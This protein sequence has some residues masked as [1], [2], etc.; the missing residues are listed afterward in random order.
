MGYFHVI[1]A[2]L[3]WGLLPIFWKQLSA[4]SST[5]VV[6]HRMLW[7]FVAMF[8]ILTMQKKWRLIKT[9]KQNPRYLLLCLCSAICIASNWFLFIWA[10][11]EGFIIEVSLG[12]FINP[13]FFVVLGALIFREKMRLGQVVA[14]FIAVVGVLYLTFAYGSF[15]YVALLLGITFTIYGLIRRQVPLDTF[16]GL[17]TE[18]SLFFVPAI[19]YLG[20]LEMQTTQTFLVQTTATK[21]YLV[22]TGVVTIAPLLFFASAAKKIPFYVLG[23]FQYIAPTLQFIIGVFV[24]SEPF[25]KSRLIG[26]SFVWFA[27][28][29]F[30]VE[31]IYFFRYKM[32]KLSPVRA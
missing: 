26:F 7:S 28:I 10:V 21:L 14:V 11:N 19:C 1:A 24:Y 8:V 31:G 32:Q 2:Y 22:S 18:T 16:E 30:F 9:L 6:F 4:M 29:V 23:F 3:L 17:A 13:L 20:Y 12:Y 25:D 5:S 27:L 15:P